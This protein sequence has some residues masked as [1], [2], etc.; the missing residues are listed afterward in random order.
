MAERRLIQHAQLPELLLRSRVFARERVREVQEGRCARSG[1]REPKTM[2]RP[3]WRLHAIQGNMRARDYRLVTISL[4][5]VAGSLDSVRPLLAVP[6]QIK[7][8]YRV[9][10]CLLHCQDRPGSVVTIAIE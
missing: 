7:L 4:Q 5:E 9:L 1:A 3:L 6:N 2:R 10:H 8:S